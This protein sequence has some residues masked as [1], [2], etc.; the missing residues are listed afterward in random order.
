M[1]FIPELKDEVYIDFDQG[2]PDRPYA[3]GSLFNGKAKPIWQKVLNAVKALRTRSGHEVALNDGADCGSITISDKSGNI[4]HL[5]TAKSSI[6]IT[7]SETLTLNA[8]DI[9]INA[10]NS[11]NVKSDPCKSKNDCSGIINI[12]AKEDIK[13][14]S[15]TKDVTV[16]AKTKNV[17]ITTKENVNVKAEK[18]V[19]M[20]GQNCVEIEGK[21]CVKLSSDTKTDIAGKLLKLRGK[22]AILRGSSKVKIN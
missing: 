17:N 19:D 20:C 13:I 3:V 1:Y 5:D 4:I 16:E 8:K 7:A 2:N 14:D 22:D 12:Q 21:Q 18:K 11:I 6:T 10:D 9:N 15:E